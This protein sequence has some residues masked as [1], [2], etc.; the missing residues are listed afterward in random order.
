MVFPGSLG[1][2]TVI[3]D[4]GGVGADACACESGGDGVGEWITIVGVGRGFAVRLG[5][6]VG[7]S[8][9]VRLAAGSVVGDASLL[10]VELL[11]RLDPRGSSAPAV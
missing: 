6:S 3:Y 5:A 4:Q 8:C 7:I 11:C 10:D 1:C 9:F 2:D